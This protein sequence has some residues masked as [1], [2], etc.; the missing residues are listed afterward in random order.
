MTFCSSHWRLDKPKNQ[1]V[2]LASTYLYFQTHMFQ[3]NLFLFFHQGLYRQ[4]SACR[5][6]IIWKSLIFSLPLNCRKPKLMKGCLFYRQFLMFQF[7]VLQNYQFG[8]FHQG[9]TW[10]MPDF[11]RLFA[12]KIIYL[13]T[14]IVFLMGLKKWISAFIVE[15]SSNADAFFL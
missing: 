15:F 2:M 3:H 5:K 10:E 12:L 1:D 13:Q 6:V 4:L 11:R 8:F 14:S 7:L 9:N